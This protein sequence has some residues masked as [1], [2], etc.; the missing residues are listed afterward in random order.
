MSYC[1]SDFVFRKS[2]VN[3]S[4][5]L[6]LLT[7]INNMSDLP[8]DVVDFVMECTEKQGNLSLKLHFIPTKSGKSK[9]FINGFAYTVDYIRKENKVLE[10]L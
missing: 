7:S 1:H 6:S 10:M 3:R 9:L 8:K 4:H 5:F 2:F